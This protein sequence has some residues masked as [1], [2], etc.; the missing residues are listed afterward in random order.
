[1]DQI[2]KEL[3]KVIK[4]K[5]TTEVGDIVLVAVEK[6]QSVFYAMVR[7]ISRDATVK[8]EWWNVALTILGVPPQKVVWTL[9]DPQFT[10]QEIFT[11]AGEGRFIQALDFSEDIPAATPPK[12][13]TKKALS[14][15]ERG[16]LRRIK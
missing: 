4:F 8:D 16:G 5:S 10:G 7:D 6:P 1:M 12:K 15:K 2:V 3:R 14:I 13:T 11:M 9:R